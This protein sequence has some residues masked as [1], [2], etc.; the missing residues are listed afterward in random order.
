[1]TASY[2]ALIP[3]AG[4][5]SRMSAEVPKQYKLL[6]GQPMLWHTVKLFHD[7]PAIQ[8]IFVVLSADD[9]EFVRQKWNEFGD[10]LAPLYCGGNTRRESVLNGLIAASN[11]I[12][13]D[14]WVLVHDAARPC[15]RHL[16]LELLIKECKQEKI[17]GILAVP[18]AD[19]V[20][21][22]D[23]ELRIAHTEPRAHLWQ[24]Q[25]PQMFRMGMLVEALRAQNAQNITD[26]AQAI[27]LLGLKPKLI[28]GSRSNIKV[29]Y[30]ED[31]EI[32]E[33]ILTNR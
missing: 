11:V 32:A 15:L 28:L 17:G 5:G 16:E 7:N 9:T 22:A 18:V 19:T 31:L 13:P 21:R 26:E 3:A 30:P 14:D 2:F 23:G 33:W 10:R 12:N 8:T 25:T 29:T 24:A 6:A 20:K 1:M 4:S 27:E